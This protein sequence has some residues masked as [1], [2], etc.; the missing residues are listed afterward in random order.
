MLTLVFP[1]L[2]GFFRMLLSYHLLVSCIRDT[3]SFCYTE[4]FTGQNIMQIN[5]QIQK[6]IISVLRYA[7]KKLCDISL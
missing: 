5:Q 3:K 4:L 6:L 2:I 7:A 1:V